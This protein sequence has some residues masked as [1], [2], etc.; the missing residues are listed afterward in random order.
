[1]VLFVVVFLRI[2]DVKT[3]E[4]HLLKG[5]WLLALLILFVDLSWC[6]GFYLLYKRNYFPDLKRLRKS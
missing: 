3:Q 5:G 2:G 4:G 6:T 1:M